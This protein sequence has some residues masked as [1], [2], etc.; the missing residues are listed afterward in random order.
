MTDASRYNTGPRPISNIERRSIKPTGNVLYGAREGCKACNDVPHGEQTAQHS[1][2][3]SSIRQYGANAA[4]SMH[5]LCVATT[6]DCPAFSSPYQQVCVEPRTSALNM[7]LPAHRR[8]SSGAC[9]YLAAS[10]QTPAVAD[11]DRKAVTIDGTDRRTNGQRI[12]D[13]YLYPAPYA[14]SV[15]SCQTPDSHLL[16][17][18]S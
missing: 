5:E 6:A 9:R 4:A 15:N 3:R 14:G 8:C 10:V 13:R 1:G 11:M 18:G 2:Y 17:T 7:T 12:P 16:C